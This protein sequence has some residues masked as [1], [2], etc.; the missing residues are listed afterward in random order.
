MSD[1]YSEE[2]IRTKEQFIQVHV[3]EGMSPFAAEDLWN[4]PM[5]ELVMEMCGG[6]FRTKS[7]RWACQESLRAEHE[8]F[9]RTSNPEPQAA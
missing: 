4:S 2:F 9:T 1:K 3:E 6:S 5:R 8:F 7:A